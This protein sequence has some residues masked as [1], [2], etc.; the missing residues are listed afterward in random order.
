[1]NGV[2]GSTFY[3]TDPTAEPDMSKWETELAFRLA[4]A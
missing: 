2:A 4:D 3:K 1:M